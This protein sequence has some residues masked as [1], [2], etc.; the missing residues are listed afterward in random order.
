MDRDSTFGKPLLTT[1]D[2]Y[3]LRADQTDIEDILILDLPKEEVKPVI[4]EK[5]PEENID[6]LVDELDLFGD[7]FG[8]D[9][10]K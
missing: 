8:V 2:Y 5:E 1:E 6:K 10:D 3:L 4:E 7:L 9:K